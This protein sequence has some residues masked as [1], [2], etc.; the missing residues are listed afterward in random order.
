M[1]MKSIPCLRVTEY[2]TLVID[3]S[4]SIE[5]DCL[6]DTH[7]RF[8][9]RLGRLLYIAISV[10]DPSYSW[11]TRLDAARHVQRDLLLHET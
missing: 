8:A 6:L 5:L 3:R 11:H 7:A 10:R 1:R 9:D 2:S 4:A